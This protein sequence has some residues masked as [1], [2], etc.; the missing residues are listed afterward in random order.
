MASCGEAG[1]KQ[2]RSFVA[3]D[4]NHQRVASVFVRG[5]VLHPERVGVFHDELVL[6]ICHDRGFDPQAFP[7]PSALVVT[8]W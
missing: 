1:G 3:C 4:E 7:D 8:H 2:G 5:T 6:M